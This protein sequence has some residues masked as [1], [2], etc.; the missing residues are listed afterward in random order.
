[1]SNVPRVA[2]YSRATCGLCDDA[3]ETI[4]EVRADLP[5]DFEEILVDGD[6][7]LERVY[8]L[9][10]PV[11]LIDGEERFELHL[12]GRELRAVLSGSHA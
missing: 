4:R 2:M 7:R 5:F 12:D 11:I 1:M 9:R 8:G 6:D 10:V 3:R